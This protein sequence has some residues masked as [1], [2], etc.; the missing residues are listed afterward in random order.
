M[1]LHRTLTQCS[2]T[3]IVQIFNGIGNIHI[4]TVLSHPLAKLPGL[5]IKLA[6]VSG[7]VWLLTTIE[8]NYHAQKFYLLRF[9]SPRTHNGF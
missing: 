9:R 5:L 6:V 7:H 4:P 8:H 1:S 2:H 3:H